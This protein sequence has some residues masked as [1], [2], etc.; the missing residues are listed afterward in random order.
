[1]DGQR[2]HT[3]A[4]ASNGDECTEKQNTEQSKW[5]TFLTPG[6]SQELSARDMRDILTPPLGSP[7]HLSGALLALLACHVFPIGCSVH[8]SSILRGQILKGTSCF[9]FFNIHRVF[10]YV[11]G[12]VRKGG[13]REIGERERERE[14]RRRRRTRRMRRRR[15]RRR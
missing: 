4:S 13:E 12:R 2:P 8:T 14:R 3:G 7:I 10:G 15:R 5:K 9:Y 1:M 6:F 11:R